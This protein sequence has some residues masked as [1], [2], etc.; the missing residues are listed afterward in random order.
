MQ[1][2]SSLNF[3]EYWSNSQLLNTLN[4]DIKEALGIFRGSSLMA[5]SA[6]GVAALG[7][8]TT[9]ERGLRVVR[10]IVLARLLAREKLGLMAVIIAATAALE[11]LTEVGIKQSVI[12]NLKGHTRHYLNAAWWFQSVRGIILY[13]LAFTVTPWVCSFYFSGKPEIIEVYSASALHS[14]F[15]IAFLSV[16]FNGFISP[17][18]HVLEKEFRFGKATMLLQGSGLVGST[19][20]IILAFVLRDAW[21]LVYGFAAEAV[22]RC[23]LSHILCPFLPRFEMDRS[24]WGE[25]LKYAR[26]M[27]GLG[28]VAYFCSNADVLLLGKIAASEQV[29]MYAWALAIARTPRMLFSAV[30]GPVLLPAFAERQYDNQSL[31]RG[32]LNTGLGVSLFV[33]PFTAVLIGS[34]GV[35][36]S[37]AYGEAFRAVAVPFGLLC[38]SELVRMYSLPLVSVYLGIG[39]P[40]M[41]RRFAV[42]R[43][44]MVIGLI[45]PFAV[46][47]GPTGAALTVLLANCTVWLLQIYDMRRAIAL[48]LG[49]YS[50]GLVR[51]LRM[52]SLVLL[53][54]VVFAIAGVDW[55]ITVLVLCSAVLLACYIHNLTYLKASLKAR[56][57]SKKPGIAGTN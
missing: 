8:G 42:I 50:S 55:G 33:M 35:V 40:H 53:P 26:G 20:T 29:G 54:S 14:M 27:L 47:L 52:A 6:R 32:I 1:S 23:V 17:R 45:Y 16:L 28:M 51:G 24:S 9:I 36:L 34:S 30:I 10:Y 19:I 25:L 11:A 3:K 21:A 44:V 57:A 41:F 4:K 31:Q 2:G 56:F 48:P 37:L 12:Q 39:K 18:A 43:L 5:R 49:E 46:Y 7:C 22:V 15:R 13:G 38:A